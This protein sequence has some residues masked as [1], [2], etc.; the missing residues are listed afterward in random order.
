MDGDYLPIRAHFQNIPNSLH[1]IKKE[2]KQLR[3][4]IISVNITEYINSAY[5]IL[6]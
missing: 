6:S 3:K 1:S 5:W 2:Q 4:P